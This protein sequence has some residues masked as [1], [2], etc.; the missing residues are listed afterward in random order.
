[1]RCERIHA[2]TAWRNG[3]GRYDCIFV[4]T[5][6]SVDGT[7]GFDIA[8]VRLIFSFK[9]EGTIFPCA[10]VHWFSWV[11]NSPNEH[12]GMWIVKPDLAED[13][14]PIASVI[15][16][17]TIFCAADLMPVYGNDAVPRY[18]SSTKSLDAFDSYYV[19]KYINHH[20]FEIAF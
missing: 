17:D 13:G 19:N 14:I 10:L 12:T 18:L 15:H 1:M 2:I 4:N 11:G 7:L 3:P 8:R 16:L 9:H 6:P 20:A 5:D